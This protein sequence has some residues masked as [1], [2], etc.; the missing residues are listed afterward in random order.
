[1]I[2][3]VFAVTLLLTAYA[4]SVAAQQPEVAEKLPKAGAIYAINVKERQ[5]IID[6]QKYRVALKARII[7]EDGKQIGLADLHPQAAVTFKLDPATDDILDLNVLV[8]P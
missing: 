1:M 8:Y 2:R 7:G 5:I 4:S 3:Y 6:N